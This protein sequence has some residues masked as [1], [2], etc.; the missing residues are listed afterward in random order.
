MSRKDR[1]KIGGG[2]LFYVNK[3]LL[4]KII[5]TYKFKENS[6][7]ILFEFSVSDKNWLLLGN[8]KPL[9]R[10]DISFINEIN[11]SLKFFSSM[12]ENF[13][14]FGDFNVSTANPNS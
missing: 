6:E 14:L 1:A 4:G 12:Y 13:L 3:N 5:N 2:L 8:C 9:S 11:L 10:N 7:I